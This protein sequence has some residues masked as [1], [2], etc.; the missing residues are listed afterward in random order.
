MQPFRTLEAVAVPL[1]L[2]KVDTGMMVPA[3]FQR[4]RR[5]PGILDY[6]QAFLHD[7]RFDADGRPRAD[8]PLNHPAWQGAQILVAGPDFGCGSS[9]ESAAYAV[10]DYGLRALVA[11]SYGDVFAGNCLQNGILPVTLPGPT[12]EHLLGLLRSQPGARVSIDL[13][14]QQ[15]RLPDGSRHG[16]DIDPTRKARLLDGLDDVGVTLAHLEQIEAFEREALAARPWLRRY[17][18]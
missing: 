2:A 5:R 9:R 18:G 8:C 17:P 3:R 7:L 16:F 15:V 10:L 13:P 4:L 11:P 14:T 12:V 6:S 1:G